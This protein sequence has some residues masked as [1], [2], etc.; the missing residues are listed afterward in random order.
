MKAKFEL[1]YNA[2]FFIATDSPEEETQLRYAFLERII[3]YEKRALDRD[4]PL[5]T[6]DALIDLYRLSRC[7]KLIDS[8]RTSFKDAA[9]QIRGV[10]RLIIDEGAPD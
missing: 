6:Q 2:K 3:V 9:W 7:R 5:A 8:Y 1:N 4:A 10:E